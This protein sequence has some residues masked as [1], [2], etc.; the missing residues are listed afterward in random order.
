MADFGIG[1]ASTVAG[2]IIS[3]IIQ[4][5][6][7]MIEMEENLRD[8]NTEF[9]RMEVFLRHIENQFQEQQRALPE[10]VQNC[11]ERMHDALRQANSLIVRAKPQPRCLGCCSLRNPKLSTQIRDWKTGFDRLFGELER[12]FS[13]SANAQQ[14]VSNAAPQAEVLLQPVPV[15]GFVGSTIESAQMQLQT[16]LEAHPQA[17]MVGV[18]GMGG[19]GKTSLLRLLYNKYKEVSSIF[20]VVIWFTVSQQYQIEKLQ[21]CIAETLHLKLEGSSD[22]D[23]RKMKLFEALGQKKFLLILDDMWH[24]IDLNEVGVK[25]GD[26]NRS[27]VLMSSRSR[28]VIRTMGASDDYSLK[29]QTLS[30]EEGWVLFRREAFTNG[31]VPKESIQAIARKIALECRG[32]PLALNVVAAAMRFKNTEDEWSRA[33][34]LMRKVDPSEP[35]TV[36]LMQNSISG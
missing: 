32:L 30:T 6:K 1:A 15:S 33:L 16:W 28:D 27:K 13:I 17:R 20:D 11:L 24:P 36:P 19:V 18:C 7:D 14:I 35:D 12:V 21:A 10:P 9:T 26:H 34:N 2:P 29:I 4:K 8:L 31:A 25:F 5:M 22:K 3:V 23:I